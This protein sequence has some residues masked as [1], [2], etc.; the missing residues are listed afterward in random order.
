MGSVETA[1]GV[2]RNWRGMGW[3]ELG[4]VCPRPQVSG[5]GLGARAPSSVQ[6]RPLRTPPS[7]PGPP[8][9]PWPP[10]SQQLPRVCCLGLFVLPSPELT[11]VPLKHRVSD[12]PQSAL[13]RGDAFCRVFLQPRRAPCHISPSPPRAPQHKVA[14]TSCSLH[15]CLGTAET[16]GPQAAAP[17]P[18]AGPSPAG[19]AG[20]SLG[21]SRPAREPGGAQAEASLRRQR[22][23]L[24]SGWWPPLAPGAWRSCRA[25]S[26]WHP[27]PR[28]LAPRCPVPRCPVLAA[29]RFTLPLS[30]EGQ[31]GP[32]GPAG[33]GAGEQPDGDLS[34][35]TV[36]R[37]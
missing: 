9:A 16:R 20:D 14:L 23:E 6:R 11:L 5:R 19:Q 13:R 15:P 8:E 32:V 12:R 36:P 33:L 7:P 34:P 37:A 18:V 25:E 28:R 21:A 4:G 29:V 27:V 10:G 17:G 1:G 31:V 30:G 24:A 22:R 2:A 3:R 26:R 35:P